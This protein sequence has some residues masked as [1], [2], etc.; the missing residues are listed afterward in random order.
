[1]TPTQAQ[2]ELA[3]L[4]SDTLQQVSADRLTQAITQAWRDG[5]VATPVYDNSLTFTQGVFEYTLPVTLTTVE[6]IEYQPNS[7]SGPKPLDSSLW[8]IV[9]V[10]GVTTLKFSNRGSWVLDS[11]YPLYLVGKYKL[12]PTDSIPAT[13]FTLQNYVISLAAFIVLK[14]IGYTKV[15]SFLQNDTSMSELLAFRNQMQQDVLMYR[16]QLATAYVDA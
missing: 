14:Q 5:Y 15:L 11:S 3:T 8:S 2:T 4:L 6:S 12:A 13:N 1:M 16:A 9:T 7:T 10:G